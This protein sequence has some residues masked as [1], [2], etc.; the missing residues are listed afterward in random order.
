MIILITLNKLHME[1]AQSVKNQPIQ[2][3]ARMKRKKIENGKHNLI[4]YDD[5]ESKIITSSEK[6]S[7]P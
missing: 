6:A 4:L 7:S 3:F 1:I 5:V 2:I